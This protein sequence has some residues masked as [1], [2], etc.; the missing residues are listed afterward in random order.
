MHRERR[1]GSKKGL[2]Y[3]AG[4]ATV[5]GV[6]WLLI[7]LFGRTSTSQALDGLAH[8][9]AIG[10]AALRQY[11]DYHLDHLGPYFPAVSG[12]PAIIPHASSFKDFVSGLKKIL[13][14]QPL[15]ERAFDWIF[16]PHQ[17]LNKPHPNCGGSWMEFGVWQGATLNGAADYRKTNCNSDPHS[18]FVYGFDTFTGLPEAWGEQRPS[19]EFSLGGRFP[20]VRDNVKLVQGLF[21]ESLPPFI[22]SHYKSRNP[23]DITYLHIDC[24][25]YAG[26]IDALTLLDKY[27]APGCVLLFDDL[28]NYPDY[29]DHEILALWEWLQATG[30]KLEVVGVKGPL[31]DKAYS[32]EMNPP[33]DMGWH[34]QSVAF[35]VL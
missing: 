13:D 18:N 8:S 34:H 7:G 5:V 26:A 17:I 19:G 24:D 12:K 20:V 14:K 2:W 31:P 4:A 1:S 16:S 22:K 33:M 29:R 30:R 27:I 28:I 9:Q 25:L 3:S 15:S 32:M 6:I 23:V 35:I 21:N 11:A 10:H